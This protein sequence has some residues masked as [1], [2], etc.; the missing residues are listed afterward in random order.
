MR[1][2]RIRCSPIGEIVTPRVLRDAR[3][4]S[5][6]GCVTTQIIGALPTTVAEEDFGFVQANR[7]Q[8]LKVFP[9]HGMRIILPHG[10][11]TRR[12]PQPW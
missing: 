9:R 12:D 11:S 4:K 10:E 2:N 8:R 1:V 5:A 3:L 7:G 6:F